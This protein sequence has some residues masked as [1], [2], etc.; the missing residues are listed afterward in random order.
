LRTVIGYI[1]V[2]I[3]RRKQYGTQQ[4]E[5]ENLFPRKLELKKTVVKILH[6]SLFMSFR[7]APEPI[8]PLYTHP[9][10]TPYN[11]KTHGIPTYHFNPFMNC[12]HTHAAK[13]SNKER[14]RRKN[15]CK[16]AILFNTPVPG[17]SIKKRNPPLLTEETRPRSGDA[18]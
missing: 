17:G 13:E 14:E 1:I 11:P 3:P 5:N 15:T 10:P 7:T 8:S 18:L 4:D 16:A 2:R 9:N 12:N 6:S